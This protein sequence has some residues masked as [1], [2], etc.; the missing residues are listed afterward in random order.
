M[1]ENIW[2]F[3]ILPKTQKLSRCEVERSQPAVVLW[4]ERG[5]PGDGEA[6]TQRRGDSASVAGGGVWGHGGEVCRKHGISQQ[7]F[8]LWKKKLRGRDCRSCASCGSCAMRTRS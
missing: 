8:Y 2:V 5:E 4:K 1:I 6:R 7:T 3:E